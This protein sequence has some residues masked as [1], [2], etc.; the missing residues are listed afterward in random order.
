MKIKIVSVYDNKSKTYDTPQFVA[1]S[2]AAI[3]GFINATKDEKSPFHQFPLDFE[4]HE[5]AEFD[6]ENGEI[7]CGIKCLAKAEHLV[8]MK[9]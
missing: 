3:R 2:M 9:K 4:L 8:E 7:K 6:N 1:S 5:I